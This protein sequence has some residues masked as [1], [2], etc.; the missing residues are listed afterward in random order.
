MASDNKSPKKNSDRRL[1]TKLRRFAKSYA[2][3]RDGTTAIEYSI[4]AAGIALAIVTVVSQL[5]VNVSSLYSSVATAYT[6]P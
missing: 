3:D 4:I 6:T 5:G 1:S 2:K